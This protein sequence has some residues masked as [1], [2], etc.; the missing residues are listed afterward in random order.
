MAI[1]SVATSDTL[2]TFRTSFNSLGTDVGDLNSLTTTDKTS[3]IAAINEARGATFAFTLRDSSSTT[4]V[5]TGNDTLNV[6]G[7]TNIA[8]TVSA[9]DTFTVSLNTT[10]TGLTSLTSTTLTDGTLTVTGGNITGAGSFTGSGTITGGTITDGT[11]SLSG[12][13]IT[14]AGSF[15]GSGTITGGTITDGTASLSSG[16]ISSAVNGNFSGTVT[17]NAFSGDG[18]SLTGLNISTDSTPQLGGNL[19]VNSNSIV[20]VSDGDI[21]ITPNGTGSVIIDGL[22]HPQADGATG[23][24]LKTD[25]AGNLA[26]AT[27]NTDLSNDTTPQLGG[28]LDLNSSDITGTGNINITGDLDISNDTQTD[29]LGV[30]TAA[31]GTTGEIR[32]TNDVTAFYSSDVT[33]KENIVNIPDPIEA[34]KKLNGVLFDWK[35]S[36]IDERGGEDGYFVRKKDV[37]VIAQDVEKVLPEAVAQRPNGVKAVKYDRLTCL[38]IEAVKKLNDKV[39]NLTK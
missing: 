31:S 33:L 37:G 7:D 24:F 18:D 26:F 17:A 21:A 25:G 2:E 23:Q 8:A 12:G 4:Q 3:I 19:D 20:S 38:L 9:T 15:T 16:S 14:G 34:L 22:S 11:A 32:A 28:D 6:V 27:V 30:G 10:V 29:S 39:E 5:I 13:N 36:Y 35:K 1:R